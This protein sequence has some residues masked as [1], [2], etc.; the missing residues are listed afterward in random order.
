MKLFSSKSLLVVVFVNI[1][2]GVVFLSVPIFIEGFL[3]LFK[4]V[5]DILILPFSFLFKIMGWSARVSSLDQ[6]SHGLIKGGRYNLFPRLCSVIFLILSGS[7]SA[8]TLDNIGDRFSVFLLCL[9]PEFLLASCFLSGISLFCIMI[10]AFLV[11]LY[12]LA[13]CK[14]EY[15]AGRK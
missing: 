10:P 12:F 3:S 1:A 11:Q 9:A 13:F 8:L 14:A 15:S 4:N 2:C 6:L 5:F 7:C